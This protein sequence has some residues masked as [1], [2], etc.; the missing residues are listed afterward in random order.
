MFSEENHVGQTEITKCCGYCEYK[1]KV[2]KIQST[3]FCI[4]TMYLCKFGAEKPTGSEDRAQKRLNLQFFKD[5]D[6]EMR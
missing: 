3:L 5:E 1:V 6:L 2:I 4:Q